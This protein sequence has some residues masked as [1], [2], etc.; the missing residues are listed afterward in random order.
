MLAS[1]RILH[2][3]YGSIQAYMVDVTEITYRTML[4]SD[5]LAN[6]DSTMQTN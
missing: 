2:K 4:G 3:D 5:I 6:N 1:V